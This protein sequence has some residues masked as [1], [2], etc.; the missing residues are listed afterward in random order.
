MVES[1][2]KRLLATT[3]PLPGV[4]SSCPAPLALS[5]PVCVLGFS[6]GKDVESG[7]PAATGG[8]GV[9]PSTR[10]KGRFSIF[11]LGQC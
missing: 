7:G 3:F 1:C 2:G 4:R 8:R 11:D 9:L 6:E 10:A 5:E